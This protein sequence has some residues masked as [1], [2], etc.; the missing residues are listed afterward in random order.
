MSN[1]VEFAGL[2]KTRN[3][4][5][6]GAFS[7]VW[8][9]GWLHDELHERAVMMKWACRCPARVVGAVVLFGL[10]LLYLPPRSSGSSRDGTEF[11]DLIP[12]YYVI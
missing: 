5:E 12:G 11:A 3:T 7:N 10:I 4:V 1:W 9:H 2:I 8:Q 6:T